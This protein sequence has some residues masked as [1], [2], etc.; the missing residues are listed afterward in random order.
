VVG[1][2]IAVAAAQSNLKR[3]TLECVSRY[4][5]IDMTDAAGSG[6]QESQV[7]SLPRP[8]PK[9]ELSVSIVFEK[10]DLKEAA[11]WAAFG[12]F[13]NIGESCTAGSRILVQESIYDEFMPLLL[14]AA[15]GVKIGNPLDKETFMG[16]QISKVQFDKTMGYIDKAKA[17]GAK[18]AIGGLRHSDKGFFVMVCSASSCGIAVSDKL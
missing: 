9:A 17:Q 5:A 6:R 15:K 11:K 13:E 12:I 1:R 8:R 10:A 7:G 14:E 2:K 18:V 16:A 3:V 4:R